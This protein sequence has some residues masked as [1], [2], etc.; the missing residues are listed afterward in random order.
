M[1]AQGLICL[2]GMCL[3]VQASVCDQVIGAIHLRALTALSQLKMLNMSKLRWTEDAVKLGLGWLLDHLPRLRVLDALPELLVRPQCLLKHCV[4]VISLR[5]LPDGQHCDTAMCLLRS[6][7]HQQSTQLSSAMHPACSYAKDSYMQGCNWLPVCKAAPV[8]K[9]QLSVFYCRSKPSAMCHRSIYH[10]QTAT[11]WSATSCVTV[12]G[13]GCGGGRA[14][15]RACIFRRTTGNGRT[16]QQSADGGSIR[17]GKFSSAVH[18]IMLGPGH[19]PSRSGT[20]LLATCR[21]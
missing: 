3:R 8:H 18:M 19:E 15:T 16:Q 2:Y 13:A 12:P 1:T 5:S 9:I 21:E 4:F 17:N 14:P 7:Q 10:R 20:R 11:Q 6:F